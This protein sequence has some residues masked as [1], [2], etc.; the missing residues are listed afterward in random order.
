M[1]VSI[2]GPEGSG[3]TSFAVQFAK[4]ARGKRPVYVLGLIKSQFP[5]ITKEQF[6]FLKNCVIIVDDANAYITPHELNKNNSPFRE[7]NI[8]HRHWNRLNIFIFHSMDDAV[9]M[10]F[11][12]SRFVYVSKKYRDESVKSNKLLKGIQP[13]EAGRKGYEF[14][15]Y[16]RY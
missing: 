10:M 2:I 9:K 14:W 11:R 15:E 5:F 1:N 13:K 7:S 8:L 12:Q 4:K 16:K 3:K 6:G